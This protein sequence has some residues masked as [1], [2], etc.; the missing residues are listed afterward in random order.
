MQAFEMISAV[1]HL[2]KDQYDYQPGVYY[3]DKGVSVYV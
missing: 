3:A 1:L 2:K